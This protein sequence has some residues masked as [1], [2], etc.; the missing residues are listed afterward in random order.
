LAFVVD[1]RDAGIRDNV[2]MNLQ[3]VDI[4]AIKILMTHTVDYAGLFPPAGLDMQPAVENYAAYR[5]SDYSWMLGRFIVP[6]LRLAEFEAAADPLLKN[7]AGRPWQLSMLTNAEV[8]DSMRRALEFNKR[9]KNGVKTE[10]VI[11]MLEIKA[12]QPE[13]IIQAAKDRGPFLTYFEIPID[14]DPES[15]LKAIQECGGRAK[16]RTGGIVEHLFPSSKNLARFIS[17]CVRVGVPFKAT[18]GLHHPIR[19]CYP[20]TYEPESK[21]AIMYGFLN[22]WLAAGFIWKGLPEAEADRILHEEDVRR[23][24][25]EEDGVTWNGRQLTIEDL[26]EVR[27][28]LAVSFGSCS[29]LEPV[30]E[31]KK[32]NLTAFS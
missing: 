29:F 15:F 26:I 3:R 27:E 20:L 21:K 24:R 18:A 22:V 16:V 1:I 11:D 10:A 25:F 28:K 8:S 31:L 17:A 5:Q 7:S 13:V 2:L 30:S 19:A 32:L 9:H 4:S 14:R 23:F 12:P 6:V